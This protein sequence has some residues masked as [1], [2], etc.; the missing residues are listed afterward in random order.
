M[1]HD[2][3]AFVT[4]TVWE[5]KAAIRAAFDNWATQPHDVEI[6]WTALEEI[7]QELIQKG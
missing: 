2:G 1:Q 6:L 5:G 7:G 3:R 4:P